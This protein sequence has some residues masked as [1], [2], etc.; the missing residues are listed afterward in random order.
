MI[1]FLDLAGQ[2]RSIQAEI[3]NAIATVIGESSFVGG[4]HVR[5]FEEAFA[6]YQQV[7]HCV[8]VG[9]GTDALEICIEALDLKP[10]SEIIVPATTFVASA[11]AVTRSGHKVVFADV[12]DDDY[13]LDVA[14]V[15]AKVTENTSA[16]LAVHLYGQPA[17]LD[18]LLAIAAKH[19]LRVIEDCAQAHGAEYSGSRVGGL[20]DVGTFSFYPGKNLGAFGDA[21]AIT[22][23]DPSLAKQCR[24]IANHGRAEKYLHEF[25]GRSSRLDGLQAA[26]LSVKLKH[27]DEWIETRRSSADTYDS[28][29]SFSDKIT[30]PHV[31][32]DVRHVY[33]LYVVQVDNRDEIAAALGE[34]DIQTGVHYPI[35]LPDQPAYQTRGYCGEGFPVA[36]KL[37]DRAL[38]LPIG[39]HLT[40]EDVEEVCNK[41]TNIL[42]FD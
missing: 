32:D 39:E 6:E 40:I 14:D 9:N 35:S 12:N 30:L 18:G 8:G 20:A 25:E 37:C 33:H 36:R 31:R 41:L 19:D 23:N 16:I 7:S 3:D 29:L 4:R 34:S 2:Y 38:S 17:P 26:V 10:G 42:A 5:Q 11:E 21:G 1:R 24:K 28:L 13:T 15:S 27:L 22:T